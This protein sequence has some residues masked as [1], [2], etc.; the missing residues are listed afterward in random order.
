MLVSITGFYD[1]SKPQMYSVGSTLM[2][3]VAAGHFPARTKV[4]SSSCEMQKFRQVRSAPIKSFDYNRNF[5]AKREMR[6]G[7]AG[8]W[9]FGH[10]A[11]FNLKAKGNCFK[12]LFNTTNMRAWWCRKNHLKVGPK[13]I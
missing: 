5:W 13:Q 2:R 12:L 3:Q 8:V 1:V 10:H 4:I 7:W 9:V 11:T 6:N